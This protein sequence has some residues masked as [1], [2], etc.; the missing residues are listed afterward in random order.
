[1]TRRSFLKYAAGLTSA[2]AGAAVC[3]VG[4]MTLVEPGWHT[5]ERSTIAVRGLPEAFDGYRLV[6]LSDIHIM[7]ERS[8][9]IVSRAVELALAQEPDA[10]LITG[11]Y[12]TGH[13]DAD[14]IVAAL[15]GL[16]APD[17]VWTVMGNHD[18]WTDVGAVREIVRSLGFTELRNAS[19]PI[20]RGADRFWLAGV[21]DIWERKHDL[22]QALADVP[23]GAPVILKA[24][25]PDNAD[26]VYPTGRVAQQVTGHSLGGQQR[27]P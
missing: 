15:G 24:H 14:R 6:Q 22:E 13:V 16:A 19:A 5:L 3:G 2:A 25:E 26:D 18:H 27:Q 9:R 17:G 23:D 8:E 4:Y 7:G 10:V 12:V 20:E 21:D 1:M 11:D